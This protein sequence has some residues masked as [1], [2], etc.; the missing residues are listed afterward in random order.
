MA[1]ISSGATNEN[2]TLSVTAAS[3]NPALIPTPTV[4]HTGPNATGTLSFT[5]V[6]NGFGSAMLPVTVNDGQPSNNIVSRSFIVTVN[7]VNDPP[8]LDALS[9]V[10]LDEDAGP[11]TVGLTGISSGATNENDTLTVTASSSNPALI[12][13]PTVT[14]TSPNAAGTLDFTPATNA[15]GTATIT[16]TVND[17]QPSNNIVSRSFTVTVNSVLKIRSILLQSSGAILIRFHGISGESYTIE[18]SA[19]LMNWSSIGTA[20]ESSPGEFEFEDTGTAGVEARF[21]RVRAP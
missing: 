8:T 2:D 4:T 17:G 11:Q 6:A 15:F 9:A 21:Y 5:P 20:S 18:A 7:P 12:P 14:Y 19:D 1:G 10:T 16:V 3:S 13:T